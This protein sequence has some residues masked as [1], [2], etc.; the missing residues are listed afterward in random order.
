MLNNFYVCSP[1]S[2]KLIPHLFSKVRKMLW[3]NSG[4]GPI[5]HGVISLGWFSNF[6]ILDNF[7]N[8]FLISE[9]KK[10]RKLKVCINM[11]NGWM[12][13]VYGIGAKGP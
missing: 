10:A 4:K 3:Q 5:A 9:P 12:Y 7:H 11:D 13:C 1:T 2:M 8:R 6:A